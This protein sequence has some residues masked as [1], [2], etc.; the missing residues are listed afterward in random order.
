LGSLRL[1]APDTGI[2]G[3]TSGTGTANTSIVIS[4]TKFTGTKAVKFN[5]VNTAFTLNPSTQITANVPSGATTG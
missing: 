4:G 3:F 1:A 2:T 5:G